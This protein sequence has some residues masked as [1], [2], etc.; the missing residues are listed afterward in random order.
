MKREFNR[1]IAAAGFFLGLCLVILAIFLIQPAQS[2]SAQCKDPSSCRTCHEVQGQNSVKASGAWHSQHA[3]Y[4]FCAVCHGG[5]K[6]ATDKAVAHTGMVLKLEGMTEGCRSCHAADLDT[7]YSSYASLLGA[8]TLS[9]TVK[10]GNNQ[11]LSNFLGAK[12]A[13]IAQ[14]APADSATDST[15][16]SAVPKTNSGNIILS[17]LLLAL[18]IGGGGYVVW[19]ER[20][21]STRRN[22]AMGLAG[23]LAAQ[24]RREHW[25]PY[26]AG[27]LLGLTG[28]LAVWIGNHLLGASGAISTLASTAL[29]SVA[30][31]ITGKTMYYQFVMPPGI[32]WE[33]IL[34]IG[35][36]FG[37][38]LGAISS[39]TFRLRWNGDPTWN[40]IF[41]RQPWKRFVIGFLGAVVLQYGAG[42]AGGCTSGLAISGGM[43][44]APSAFLFMAGMFV[45]G[46]IVALIV[47]R[48]RY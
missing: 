15:V 7:R 13:D 22:P 20:R 17:A 18:V 9:P 5:D 37:G 2:V 6:K 14:V 11:A 42:I 32:G 46:I 21:L 40:K 31:D 41:G 4:D 39:K 35:V 16:E 36:F 19:N 47:Y 1:K 8:G 48:G 24:V 26:A 33:V 12:S 30:P 43:L 23:W 29:N 28:I 25:S 10:N 38:M 34:L 44:L 45:S 3:A 27:V